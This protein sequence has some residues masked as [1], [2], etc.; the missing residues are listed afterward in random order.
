MKS[1]NRYVSA[2]A[3]TLIAISGEAFAQ[4]RDYRDI[5]APPLRSFTIPQPKR[6][7]LPNGMVLLLMEDR[8]L[9]IIRGTAV[10]RGGERDVPASKA[11]LMG[12]Y[13]QSW[14]TGGTQNRTGDQLD[15]FLESRAAIVETGGDD[16]STSISLNV[17]KNDF[18]TVLPIFMD[19][20]RNPAFRQD[21]IDLAKTQANAVIS[22]RNDEAG[23][24]LARE[25]TKL[26]YG[27]DS[28]YARQS[29][30]AT[31]AAITRDDLLEFHKRYVHP[32]NIVLGIV[33]DFDSAA[34]ERKLRQAFASWKRGPAAPAVQAMGTPAKP[35]VYFVAK[36]DVNQS[37]IAMVHPGIVRNNPDYAALQVLNEVLNSE[38]LFPRIR[39]QQGLAY[40]V[41]GVVGSDWDHPGLFRAQVG[42]K[43][44]TTAQ[45]IESLRTELSALHSQPFTAEE[46]NRAKESILN[47]HVFTMDSRQKILAQSMNLEFYGYPANWYQRYP[48]LVRQVTIDDVARVAKKYVSPDQI[49]LLVV[50]KQADFD[51]PLS[52]YGAVTPIDITI[53]ELRPASAPAAGNP[54]GAALI[55][56]VLRFAGG[57]AAIDNVKAVRYEY[58]MARQ[59]PQG[60]MEM[61]V[62][63]LMD[64]P[65]RIHTIMKMPMGEMTMVMTPE[66]SFMSMGQMGTRDLP[67]SQA[68]AMRAEMKQDMLTIL[69]Y[70]ERYT[71]AV[72]GSEKVGDVQADVLEIAT[73]GQSAKWLVDPATGKVLRKVAQDNE[74]TEFTEFRT[75]EGITFPSA[76]RTIV[77]GEQ[78]G[79]MQTKSID[80]NPPID[81]ALFVK[82]A[83]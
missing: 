38:R 35:G 42:T 57:K 29:E 78:V 23:A 53:P 11:G 73:D 56:K 79:T 58:A 24:I 19:L 8:E 61:D 18:D 81:A 83:A 21:K 34:M 17:L 31:I 71:F 39:T 77:N 62:Q 52:T 3:L 2:A 59:T 44:E 7:V 28:P 9:P 47:A 40:S 63:V 50:G 4:V 16:D 64:Y 55:Q 51:K 30:Y 82:P 70:P 54:Q 49:R 32:N 43:S 45:A 1:L 14:R 26:G 37:N 48:D 75:F 74:I 67:S 41:F 36:D 46:V 15:E 10:I 20:L 12:I 33:G 69:K 13:G 66:A 22:R 72:T 60:A 76:S 65:N 25:S 68:D 5:K 27:P 6:V 80:I